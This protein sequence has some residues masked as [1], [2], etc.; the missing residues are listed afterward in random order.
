M[1]QIKLILGDIYFQYKYG[2]YLL[3]ALFTL[4]YIALLYFLPD[5]WKSIASA[6]IIFSDPALIGLIFMGSII[7]FEKSERVL[8]SI[9]VSPISVQ[10]YIISKVVSITVISLIS[11]ILIAW[12]AGEIAY[13]PTFFIGIS[14]GSFLFSLIGLIFS[15]K[16][17]TLN[18]FLLKTMPLMSVAMIPIVP[19]LIGYDHWT[20]QLIPSVAVINLIMDIPNL[21]IISILVLTLWIAITY[22]YTIVSVKKMFKK[23]GGDKGE[24]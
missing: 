12:I 16:S 19:Y 8:N 9:A 1:K 15:I 22:Y 11:G 23:L 21:G 4:T 7:L 2:F 20:M 3:Y 18:S 6:V 5:S 17:A 10:Q 14:L 13:I 24:F